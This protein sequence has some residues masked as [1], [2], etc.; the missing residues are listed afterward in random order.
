[1][2]L[3]NARKTGATSIETRNVNNWG[4][5]MRY[6][7]QTRYDNPPAWT[8]SGRG[9][10]NFKGRGSS[11]GASSAVSTPRPAAEAPP[12]S[13]RSTTET[14]PSDELR[15]DIASLGTMTPEQDK[16]LFNH[17]ADGFLNVVEQSYNK[18]VALDARISRRL[19][20]PVYLH[21]M[22]QLYY[23]HLITISDL[24][25]QQANW[26]NKLQSDDFRRLIGAD[27]I[28]I[29]DE[30]WY[31]LKGLGRF[32]D[33]DGL[34]WCPNVPTIVAPRE[35]RERNRV[36]FPGGDFG[37][38]AAENHN[39]YENHISPYTTRAFTTAMLQ[40]HAVDG[41]INYQP[42]PAQLTPPNGQATP[43][44]LGFYQNNRRLHPE[45]IAFYDQ[46][47]ANWATG[48]GARIGYN[49]YL[50][51]KMNA[52]IHAVRD[53]IKTK[54]GMPPIDQGSNALYGTIVYDGPAPI[55]R[56]ATGTI[57][58]SA[59]MD[60]QALSTATISTYRRRRDDEAPGY[61]YTTAA[62]NALPGWENTL[63]SEYEM[64]APFAPQIGE[65][66]LTLNTVNFTREITEGR[67]NVILEEVS[68]LTL[69]PR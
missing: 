59:E 69:I 47:N 26:I 60:P 40:D 27:T 45:C 57:E 36:R 31:W 53:R 18:L 22:N 15:Y 43:N 14:P 23:V 6:H 63:N 17:T 19:P 34:N 16:Y 50:W 64:E 58:S 54:V 61:C 49:P 33:K 67:Y 44:F 7:P 66:N 51:T 4:D 30:I 37:L 56:T 25:G 13:Y 11:R 35:S 41:V 42:L 48:Y 21:N 1:M 3:H 39:V 12:T 52:A 9:Q 68:R 55:L 32:R 10:R 24:T 46:F 2:S 8:A 62:G 29:P 28:E 38:P 65:L 20:F 5:E